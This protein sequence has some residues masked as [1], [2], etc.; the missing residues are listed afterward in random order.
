[1]SI[2]ST[3]G[4]F[5]YTPTTAARELAAQTPGADTDTFTATVTDGFGGADTVEVTVTVA[6]AEVTTIGDSTAGAPGGGVVIGPDGTRYQVAS[7]LT[8]GGPM[9]FDPT[10]PT[11]VSILAPN[12]EVLSTT[13]DF[14]GYVISQPVARPNGLLVTSV[15]IAGGKTY[16]TLV[17]NTGTVTQLKVE[18]GQP[19]LPLT[20]SGGGAS[21]A[22]IAK[23]TQ[24]G[25]TY[26]L[27]AVA[28]N[29][30]ATTYP[31][32]ESIGGLPVVSS[33]GTLYQSMVNLDTR[34]Y[35]VLVVSPNGTSY[36]TTPVVGSTGLPV[37]VA[38]DGKAYQ[39]I[40]DV[41][42]STGAITTKIVTIDGPTPTVRTV[43]GNPFTRLEAGPNGAV[44][45]AT[46]GATGATIVKVTSTTITESAAIDGIPAN[47]PKIDANGN[48]YLLTRDLQ[49]GVAQVTVYTAGGNTTTYVLAGD[50]V[51]STIPSL[52]GITLGP[53][54]KAYVPINDGNGNYSVVVVGTSGV[55]DTVPVSG[56]PKHLLV[57]GPD[58]TPY[59][60]VESYDEATGAVQSTVVNLSNGAAS[61]P[62]VGA[63]A[64]SSQ[65]QQATVPPLVVGPDGTLYLLAVAG[66]FG[67]QVHGVA[68]DADGNLIDEF[69][70]AGFSAG[71]IDGFTEYGL[72]AIKQFTFDQDGTAYVTVSRLP[73]ENGEPPAAIA[74][75]L[76]A[77][78]V[79]KVAEVENAAGGI[80]SVGGDGTV[81]LTTATVDGEGHYST[82]VEVVTPPAVL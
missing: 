25:A 29:G 17:S 9:G 2:N 67:D 77:S 59:Q 12:G 72:P 37:M 33:N 63:V 65:G 82:T 55:E 62:I 52:A 50:T 28:A 43:A 81:Y 71:M 76:N 60:V 35:R 20:L 14:P 31:L 4:A 61:D 21:Y 16:L 18:D 51:D 56:E 13:T 46:A 66:D 70:E 1:V 58:G 57:F 79:T 11:R 7:D 8:L 74:Y 10:G 19:L 15:D 34:E 30:T 68:L 75:A 49:S 80:I 27:V 64:T 73:G 48:A 32:D 5:T 54:G 39:A 36:T 24:T 44:Y 41:N 23:Q 47:T 53:D 78:G 26:K 3:T 22:L 69:T 42:Q 40:V 6:S 45:Y 38:S